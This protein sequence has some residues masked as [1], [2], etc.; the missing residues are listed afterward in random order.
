MQNELSL[1]MLIW[2]SVFS[3]LR[4][5]AMA[6]SSALLIVCLSG[7]DLMFMCV[8]EF[9]LGF[10]TP[11]PNVDFPLTCEPS[12]YT[13]SRGFHIR[14]CC[15]VWRIIVFRRDWVGAGVLV[16]DF[17]LSMLI[18]FGRVVSILCV[19][20]LCSYAWFKIVFRVL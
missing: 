6:A 18:A 11:T 1:E 15:V 20:V 13:K 4:T 3:Y 10:T 16:Y 9:V 19:W 8:M 17:P 12:V 14:L 7:C 2:S 5:T